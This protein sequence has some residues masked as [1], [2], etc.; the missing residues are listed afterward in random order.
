MV[1]DD[2]VDP[3][4]ARELR[5][6]YGSDA[7]VHGHD[8]AR[9]VGGELAN[10]LRVQAVALLVA[11][12]DVGADA[13]ADLTEGAH[14]DRRSG[15]AVDVV[16]PIDDDALASRERTTEARHRA[17]EIGHRRTALGDPRRQEIG[18][19]RGFAAAGREDTR[20]ER[21]DARGSIDRP[22][23]G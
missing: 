23:V 20:D 18:H 17:V 4:L 2:E 10:R 15:D 7:A 16:V 5:L 14:E 21:R 3:Q 19:L 22:Y 6:T 12:G 11:I 8:D 13:D 1:G 9:P